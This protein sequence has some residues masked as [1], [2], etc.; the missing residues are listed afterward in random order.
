MLREY[1]NTTIEATF[2]KALLSAVQ[3]PN[4][5]IVKDGD[6]I[7]K[8]YFYIYQE[9]IVR[10]TETGNIGK[11]SDN[12]EILQHYNFCDMDQNIE[13]K[14]FIRASYYSTELHKRFGQ[15]LRCIRDLYD[16]DLMGMYNC[17]SY[18]LFSDIYIG[19][20]KNQEKN[21]IFVGNNKEKKVL[22]IPIKF[23]Q[24]Y[25]IAVTS[26]KPVYACPILK[27]PNGI[28]SLAQLNLS[29]YTEDT[30][31]VRLLDSMQFNQPK[32]ISVDL[33][34]DQG[35]FYKYERYLY[36]VVQLDSSNSS[37]FVVLE[38][39]YNEYNTVPIIGMEDYDYEFDDESVSIMYR[40]KLLEMN[41][42]I[43]YA[44]SNTIMQYLVHNAITSRDII[45]ENISYA[46][47]LI[48]FKDS[49]NY[50]SDN[51]KY[52]AFMKFVCRDI[53]ADEEDY[54]QQNPNRVYRNCNDVTGFIDKQIEEWLNANIS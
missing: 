53:Q 13:F 40:P 30:M 2:L 16:I 54:S 49:I 34:E 39:E 18:E 28:R 47:R 19:F 42:G 51:V 7:F 9:K 5:K 6:L 10:C 3:L 45:G 26:N 21:R 48:N 22:A 12:Y 36:L 14:E 52:S 44:Y 33:S 27:L 17:F 20:D 11:E 4:F 37:S 23:N 35:E 38:G 29:S 43:S 15:Y 31:G 32:Q 46:K 50:W 1:F 41:D 24:K 25:T 8:D